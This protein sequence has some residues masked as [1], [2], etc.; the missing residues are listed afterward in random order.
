MDKL[1]RIKVV[2]VEKGRTGK[3]LAGQLNKSAVTVSSW[4][5]N[6]KQPDLETLDAIAKL[7]KVDVKELLN[8]TIQD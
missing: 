5:T 3:W 7:L 6:S 2:L 8:D 4:C 1:N